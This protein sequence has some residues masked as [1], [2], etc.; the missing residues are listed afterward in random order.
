[1]EEIWRR[2]DLQQNCNLDA[3]VVA[4]IGT[5][6]SSKTMHRPHHKSHANCERS[7]E[8]VRVVWR[9]GREQ[10]I[11]HLSFV[12]REDRGHQLQLHRLEGVFG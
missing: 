2:V 1:M 11:N 4:R 6:Q 8:S 5:A 7:Q 3:Y 12:Q 10:S 9:E